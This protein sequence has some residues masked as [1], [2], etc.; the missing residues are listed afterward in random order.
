MIVVRIVSSDESVR[1]LPDSGGGGG[2]RSLSLRPSSLPATL[3]Q[4]RSSSDCLFSPGWIS[5]QLSSG[6]AGGYLMN[7]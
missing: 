4:A 6:T 2:G 3:G 1:P 7:Y 5:V